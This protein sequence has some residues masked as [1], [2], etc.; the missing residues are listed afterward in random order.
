MVFGSCR[1]SPQLHIETITWSYF[2]VL[3]SAG[4]VSR[5]PNDVEYS[6]GGI[7]RLCVLNKSLSALKS[8]NLVKENDVGE[9][10]AVSCEPQ[11]RYSER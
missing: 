1:S 10:I 8:V 2:Y 3:R 4:T 6:G 5:S 9:L 7:M 11:N